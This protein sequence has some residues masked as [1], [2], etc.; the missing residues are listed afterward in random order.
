MS[1]FDHRRA[2]EAQREYPHAALTEQIVGAAIE[3][4][5]HLGP[6]LLESAYEECLCHELARRN[7]SFQR[8]VDLPIE[9]KGVKLDCGYRMDLVVQDLIVIEIKAVEKILPIFE[10]QLITYLKLANK[11]V[12][13]ILNFHS[14]ILTKGGV[15][16][17]ALTQK[18][19]SAS[20]PLR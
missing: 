14:E 7:L 3:V 17:R 20:A 8:Q 15:V 6:G 4:H 12:G 1:H 18:S 9:H 19:L 11:P 16:R 2:A 10:A 13:L 5:R